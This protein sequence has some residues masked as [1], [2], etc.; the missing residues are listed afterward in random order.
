MAG[1]S[2]DSPVHPQPH[3]PPELAPARSRRRWLFA[4]VAGWTALLL[5][6][7]YVS[8]RQDEP[9]VREQRDLAQATP[10]VNRALGE[11]LAGAGSEVVA[12]LTGPTVQPGCRITPMRD[13]A[14][15][16]Y[17]I[18]LRTAE[19]DT[20]ALLDRLAQR[21]P[22]DYQTAVR[23]GADGGAQTL[24]AEAG[25][26]VGIRGGVT[27]PGV[28]RLTV[29]TGCRPVPPNFVIANPTIGLPIDDEPARVLGALGVPVTDPLA[30]TTGVPC[31]AGGA[32]Y[33][34]RAAG[35]GTPPPSFGDALRP[36]AGAGAVV[37]T[38]QPELYAYRAGPLS[39]V[40]EAT[41]GM[42]RVAT[43]TGCA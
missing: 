36:L 11:L 9:T 13:G 34:T 19:A 40:I 25:E 18:T 3:S 2:T 8:V 28:V 7:T 16:D 41:D 39:V 14:T 5:L 21:L 1:V 6:V 43:T 30:R 20:P 4:A 27:D 38:D 26:F 31:P 24:R 42:I 37:I 35:R 29:A 10:V 15:L 33:T 12:E 17:T 22:D 23:H 32:G